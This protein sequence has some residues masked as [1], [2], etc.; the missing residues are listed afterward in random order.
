MMA[1]QSATLRSQVFCG[2]GQPGSSA[3]EARTAKAAQMRFIGHPRARGR[4][5]Y[6]K[7]PVAWM[8]YVLSLDVGLDPVRQRN[9]LARGQRLAV[10]LGLALHLSHA[11]ARGGVVVVGFVGGVALREEIAGGG[12]RG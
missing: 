7:R 11:E 5:A 12:Q 4:L 10:G 6:V 8:R 1:S 2:A 9:L 3:T